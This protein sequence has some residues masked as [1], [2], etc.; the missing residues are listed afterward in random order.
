MCLEKIETSMFRGI[1]KAECTNR[2]LRA[3]KMSYSRE[4]IVK[5]D[6]IVVPNDKK[7]CMVISA[8]TK[9]ELLTNIC[10]RYGFNETSKQYLELWSGQ[11]G[12][13]NRIRLDILDNIPNIYNCIWIRGVV[14]N[15]IKI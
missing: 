11:I 3:N 10:E 7:G 2:N 13:T 1:G 6:N 4:Y 14:K 15:V 8:S 9:D 12:Y 5:I